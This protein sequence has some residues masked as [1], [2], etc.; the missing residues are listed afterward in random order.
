MV[1]TAQM[2][3]EINYQI[4]DCRTII[5]L[6]KKFNFYYAEA[7]SRYKKLKQARNTI[8]EVLGDDCVC[9]YKKFMEKVKAAI[10]ACKSGKVEPTTYYNVEALEFVIWLINE[11]FPEKMNPPTDDT[12]AK[13][14]TIWFKSNPST[15]D[16]K[17]VLKVIHAHDP[18]AFVAFSN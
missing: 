15:T 13:M 4:D 1:D 12:C 9:G 18:D 6:C 16:V 5:N 10:E 8:K 14:L 7:E 3:A 11:M 17:E 2:L